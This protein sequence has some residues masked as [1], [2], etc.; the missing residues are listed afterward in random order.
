M[1]IKETGRQIQLWGQNRSLTGLTSW[2]E[3]EEEEEETE[4]INIRVMHLYA[5]K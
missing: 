2:P 5:V 1:N 3:E 4:V